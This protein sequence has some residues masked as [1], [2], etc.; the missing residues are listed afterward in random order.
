MCAA[1]GSKKSSS[2]H[3]PNDMVII[4]RGPNASTNSADGIEAIR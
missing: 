4:I 1:S 2:E 3:A